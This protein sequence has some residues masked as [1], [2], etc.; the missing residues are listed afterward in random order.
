MQ[1][2]EEQSAP[3]A[4]AHVP[5]GV[6]L[7][8]EQAVPVEATVSPQTW[9]VQL[10]MWHSA[11]GCGH[12]D[13]DV[14][15]PLL[16]LLELLLELLVELVELLVVPE[17]PAPRPPL[18]EDDAVEPPEPVA[19]PCPPCPL[20]G[21]DVAWPPAPPLNRPVSPI[22][23]PAR[24][25]EALPRRERRAGPRQEKRAFMAVLGGLRSYAP[26][27]AGSTRLMFGPSLSGESRQNARP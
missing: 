24:P 23:Q 19:P 8:M 6:H 12:S 1:T 14:H 21:A 10:A 2:P 27:R 22:P 18:P 11:P 16:L 26:A 13:A 20:V 15:P 7:P 5:F 25:R 9:P 4:Q 17:P 3:V